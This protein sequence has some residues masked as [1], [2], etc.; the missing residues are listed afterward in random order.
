[1][2]PSELAA[3]TTRVLTGN[4]AVSAEQQAAV[5]GL[6]RGRLGQSTLGSS[7]LTRFQEH[8]GEGSA[9]IVG[10]VL[11]D[12]FR[13]DP[14]F[15]DLMFAVLRVR[16]TPPTRRTASP[17]TAASVSSPL[18]LTSPPAAAVSRSV[19]ARSDVWK[20]WLLGLP[21]AIAAYVLIT[22]VAQAVGGE[23]ALT[24]VIL[25]ASTCLAALGIWRG[26]RILLHGTRGWLLE[27]GTL[28]DGLVLI[29]LFLWLVGV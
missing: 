28:L 12:E 13:A 10:A 17:D 2:H 22:L 21:Q 1:M 18:P 25:L 16:S 14:D 4:S 27:A 3:A 26:V 24:V 5:H 9:A 29:R 11:A 6:V 19:P 20:V 8:P 23:H 7:A 15:A